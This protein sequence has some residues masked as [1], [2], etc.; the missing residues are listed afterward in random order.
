M[1]CQREIMNE[2]K[3]FGLEHVEEAGFYEMEE[4]IIGRMADS[5]SWA[6][7]HNT[8][9]LVGYKYTR[10]NGGSF[11][12]WNPSCEMARNRVRVNASM[13]TDSGVWQPNSCKCGAS[14]RPSRRR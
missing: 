4:V 5:T 3:R 13:L 11:L 1:P 9:N 10:V 2:R 8:S 6:S 14:F 12:C 7:S